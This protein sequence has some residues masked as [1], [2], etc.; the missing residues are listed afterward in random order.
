MNEW[1][2]EYMKEWISA[3]VTKIFI[4]AYDQT[5]QNGY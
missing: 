1:I 4:S 5:D 2:N 3:T